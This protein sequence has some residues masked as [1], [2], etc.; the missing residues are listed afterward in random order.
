MQLKQLEAC[1][2]WRCHECGDWQ[3]FTRD[4]LAAPGPS[5]QSSGCQEAWEAAIPTGSE[6]VV[7][8][9]SAKYKLHSLAQVKFVHHYCRHVLYGPVWECAECG[10]F[11]AS[12]LDMGCSGL[13]E[14]RMG[15]HGWMRS[16]CRH[17]RTS[18]TGEV[19]Q[20]RMRYDS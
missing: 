3:C 13:P 15:K 18:A 9:G 19:R 5:D 8:N 4:Y 2:D 7:A 14:Q 12:P 20:Y 1:N 10:L 11:S 17:D 16:F 6:S